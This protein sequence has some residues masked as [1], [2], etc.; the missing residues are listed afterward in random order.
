MATRKAEFVVLCEDKKHRSFILRYMRRLGFNHRQIRIEPCP[1]GRGAGEQC[2]RERYPLVAKAY[3][4]RANHGSA[5]LIAIVDAD[6]MS[7]EKR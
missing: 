7:V 5:S 1:V 6:T 3:R 2:V 4:S